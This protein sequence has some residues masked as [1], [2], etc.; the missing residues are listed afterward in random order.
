VA[1]LRVHLAQHVEE[2]GLD[3]KVQRLVVQ[4]QLGEQTQ[5]LAVDLILNKEEGEEKIE[6][7][8]RGKGGRIMV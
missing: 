2:E 8:K 5:V 4:E 1:A 7:E 6:G 3:V